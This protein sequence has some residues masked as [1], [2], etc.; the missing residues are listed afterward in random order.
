M[1]PVI[2]YHL[3]SML[4]SAT[5]YRE[6]PEQSPAR[7]T[8]LDTLWTY[9]E[10]LR[11]WAEQ[12]LSPSQERE[13]KR[14]LGLLPRVREITLAQLTLSDKLRATTIEAIMSKSDARVQLAFLLQ[15]DDGD[16]EG[17]YWPLLWFCGQ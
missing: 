13:I 5:V 1:L 11:H 10:Q 3:D 7:L 2:A 12:R 8:T 9:E 15:G 14:L 6:H 4:A 16:E 17:S